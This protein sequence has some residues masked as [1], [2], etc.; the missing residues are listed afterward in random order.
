MSQLNCIVNCS[1]VNL[2]K[3]NCAVGAKNRYIRDIIQLINNIIKSIMQLGLS[4]LKI[5]FQNKD[6]WNWVNFGT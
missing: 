3:Y 6:V 5:K 4:D 1:I 2:N